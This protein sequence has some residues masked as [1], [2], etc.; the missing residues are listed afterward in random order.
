MN[1]EIV[2]R[3]LK[4]GILISPQS[5]QKIDESNINEILE[6]AKSEGVLVFSLQEETS[7][8]VRKFQKKQ[9]LSPKDF[10]KYYNARFDGIKNILLKKVEHTV[11]VSNAKRSASEFITIGMVREKTPKGFIIEDITGEAEVIS[12]EEDISQDDVVAIRGISKEGMIFAKEIILPDIPLSSIRQKPNI[13]LTLSEN[14]V[15]K[16]F[17]LTPEAV[18]W[19]DKKKNITNP[20]WITIKK[21]DKT[22]TILV[23]KP[24]NEIKAKD[25]ISLLKK[26]HLY[27]LI[28]QIEGIEDNF[29]IEPV[30][31]LIW[32]IQKEK[33][34]ENY[35]GIMIVSG[36]GKEPIKVDMAKDEIEF[37]EKI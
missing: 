14:Q 25:I 24:A 11:S 6:K 12:K 18:Y 8:E 20:G 1:E 31:N 3:F 29:L 23:Y 7:V 35:K 16:E 30:P 28:T 4:E 9:K 32:L 26:R 22:A 27:P 21:D 34:R 37:C 13:K 19:S 2:R 15:T 36:D 10:A 5:L 33:F 17:N